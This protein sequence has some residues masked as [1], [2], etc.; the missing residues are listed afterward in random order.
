MPEP[1]ISILLPTHS[2]FKNGLLAKSIESVLAQSYRNFELL[3]ADDASSDGSASY[4]SKLQRSDRRVRHLRHERNIGLLAYTLAHAY[5]NASGEYIAF[6]FDDTEW[7]PNHLE[8]LM[9]CFAASSS[10]SM[11]YGGVMVA[12]PDT[13]PILL[14]E[15]A[16]DLERITQDNYIGHAGV[17]LRRSTVDK[18]GWLDPHVLVKRTCDWDFWL[19]IA[20]KNLKIVH[21]PDLVAT[22]KGVTQPDS[23]GMSVTR[24][25]ALTRKYQQ[26]ERDHLLAPS[27][28]AENNAPMFEAPAWMNAEENEQLR[29]LNFEH[30]VR[31]GQ[32]P[33]AIR[34]SREWVE[35]AK[36]NG[37]EK[38]A[39]ELLAQAFNLYLAETRY[40][41]KA[42][43]SSAFALNDLKD[44]C[45]QW[46]SKFESIEEQHRQLLSIHNR[47]DADHDRLSTD[48]ASL[49]ALHVQQKAHARRLEE[50]RVQLEKRVQE[51][52]MVNAELR[53]SHTA[54]QK[55]HS[56]LSVRSDQFN[57]I[58]QKYWQLEDKYQ[59]LLRSLSWRIT[60]PLRELTRV[61]RQGD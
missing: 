60:K 37:A 13:K 24:Y 30:F 56:E 20:R 45:F 43:C 35:E 2:R 25:D 31:T 9:N 32:L 29:V 5:L 40:A 36:G 44:Q 16:F 51:I 26:T 57:D 17:M 12:P 8:L 52:E 1:L 10:A 6:A 39:I 33:E 53:A 7:L 14:G 21:C 50:T 41:C 61:Y 58:S 4:L 48:Y 34:V 22:E 27:L 47:L 55:D 42:T 49:E 59:N 18:V 3:I 38:E 15:K 54:L 28:V 46:R 23:L 11:V 19:R